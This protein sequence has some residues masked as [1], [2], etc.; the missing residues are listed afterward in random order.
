MPEKTPKIPDHQIIGRIG[1]G[2]YGEVWL[3][4]GVTGVMRAVKV[5]SRTDF[6]LDKTFER[7]FEGIKVFEPISRRHQGL[8]DILHVG[9]NYEDNFYYYVME[10]ADD[11]VAGP[12]IVPDQYA[13]K[14]L[15]NE[16]SN[17]GRI[18]LKLCREWGAVMADALHHIHNAGLAHRDIKPSNVIF[19]GGVPKIAD[20]GLV[21]A[22]GQ[23]TFVGTE[24][25]VPPEGPGEP[26]ADIY[27]LGMVLY[28]MSSGRDRFDF[29][30]VTEFSGKDHEKIKWHRLNEI[31]CK[32][33]S[34]AASKRYKTADQMKE[35][36][37]SLDNYSTSTRGYQ[38]LSFF[39][40][41]LL[42]VFMFFYFYQKPEREVVAVKVTK[43]VA[44]VESEP[45]DEKIDIQKEN[46]KNLSASKNKNGNVRIASVP[47]G[48]SVFKISKGGDREFLG[49]TSPD[50][51]LTNVSVGQVSYELKLDNYRSQIVEGKVLANKTLPLGGRLEFFSPPK[52]AENWENSIGMKFIFRDNEHL[53]L[54]PINLKVFKD[55]LLDHGDS[56][57]FHEAKILVVG[58]ALKELN[59][60]AL[61]SEDAA[62]AFFDWLTK[63]ERSKGFLSGKQIYKL[64]LDVEHEKV[65]VKYGKD[66]F[67]NRFPLFACVE[68]PAT[69]Q[70]DISSYPSSASVYI[71]G[72]PFGKT[73]LSFED[74]K[75]ESLEILFRLKGY[76]DEIRLI[77]LQPY[78]E[79]HVDVKMRLSMGIDMTKKWKN[80][81]GIQMI[82]LRKGAMLAAIETRNKDYEYFCTQNNIKSNHVN[83]STN[84]G[85]YPVANITINKIKDFCNWLTNHEREKG[86][87]S[88][89]QRYG[90]PNDEDWSKAAGLSKEG[91]ASPSQRDKLIEGV[92]PWGEGWPPAPR[93]LNLADDSASSWATK[94]EY[95]SS[96]SDG[97]S[98]SSPV[99]SFLPNAM[100]FYD[101]SGNVWEWVNELYG[102]DSNFKEWPVARGGSYDSHL[103]KKFLASYRNVQPPETNGPMYGFRLALFE[104]EL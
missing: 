32:A 76:R 45:D 15:S 104:E 44:E 29:P 33:C 53:S 96:Y 36:I 7:E 92:F 71:N 24:G 3:A 84:S 14:N 28:E 60:T 62:R 68:S 43:E 80:S 82:P 26:Q 88:Y 66:V 1:K 102:G 18:S 58:S 89:S 38:K 61:V 17:Q 72:R 21:A 47:L 65:E 51:F 40:A 50:L 77:N 67:E 91:G 39:A 101:I 74:M 52:Y 46:P 22:T 57:D 103:R 27:S 97:F 48:A 42:L 2:S 16:I 94:G 25:F 19:V 63:V 99:G 85:D 41:A 81:L 4:R 8:V 98:L 20:I 31:I 5:V 12:V 10:L 87:I 56:F 9:R 13:P 30:S 100:G 35:D 6:E 54:K 37:V 34:N 11:Q 73:D 59:E 49:K 90:L 78:F 69:S 75:P 86:I 23:R 55:F 93:V 95:L 83:D 64:R 70:L 79:H